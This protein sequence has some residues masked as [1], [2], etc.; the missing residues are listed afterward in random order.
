MAELGKRL[1]AAREHKGWTL[2]ELAVRAGLKYH[3]IYSYERGTREPRLMQA[4][5]LA[6]ALGIPVEVL[7][8]GLADPPGK[9]LHRRTGAALASLDEPS[10]A[11]IPAVPAAS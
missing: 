8:K 1:K 7:T 2:E 9:R 6:A 11:A 3:A 10:P 5:Q 4:V